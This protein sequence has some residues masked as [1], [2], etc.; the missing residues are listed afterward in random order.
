MSSERHFDDNLPS[1]SLQEPPPFSEFSRIL[2]VDNGDGIFLQVG[3]ANCL[4]SDLKSVAIT[5]ENAEKL[6]DGFKNALG[7]TGQW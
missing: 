3:T 4:D 6:I 2:L 5:K 1:G 7:N